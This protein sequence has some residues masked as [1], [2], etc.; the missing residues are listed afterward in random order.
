[1]LEVN[2][3]LLFLRPFNKLGLRYMVTGSVAGTIYGEPRLTHDVDIV[4][5]LENNQIPSLCTEFSLDEFYC[6]PPEVIAIEQKRSMRGHFNLIH[7]KTGFKADI[8]LAGEDDLNLWGLARRQEIVFEGETL[9]FASVEYVILRKL[10]YYRDGG[11]EKH[12]RDIRGMLSVSADRIDRQ[13]LEVRVDALGLIREWN[14]IA[15]NPR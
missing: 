3:F 14:K 2:L 8:Y 15:E 7:H 12:L 1:M 9:F 4:L 11:S 10:Q 13:E 6:P 5:A